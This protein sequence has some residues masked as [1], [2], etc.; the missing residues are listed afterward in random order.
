LIKQNILGKSTDYGARLVITNQEF[1]YNSVDDMPTGFYKAGVPVSY[2]MAMATPFFAGWIQNFFVRSFEEFQFKYPYYDEKE[3][4]VVYLELKDPALQFSD[5][6]IHEMMEEYL[7]SYYHRFDPIYLE[8]T[9]KEH[10]KIMF[11]FRGRDVT[12]AEFDPNDPTRL[13]NQRAF[14]ITDL[15]YMAAH[16][17]CSDKHIYITRYPMADHLGIFPCGI[18]VLSTTETV[19]MEVNGKTYNHYP[20]IVVGKPSSNAFKE[21]ICLNNCYLKAKTQWPIQKRFCIG[22]LLNCWKLLKET[23]SSEAS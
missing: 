15:M 3:K 2:C 4:K 10:P 1:V 17:I 20:K 12:D 6:V 23:I 13:L 14:T 16:D 11:H 22:K 8:T 18:T 9:S 21:V 19:K 7:H 5:E